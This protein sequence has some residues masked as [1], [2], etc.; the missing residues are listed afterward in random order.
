MVKGWVKIVPKLA[1]TKLRR[2]FQADGDKSQNYGTWVLCRRMSF[3][4]LKNGF[5]KSCKVWEISSIF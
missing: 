1:T 5:S 2:D 3:S 4:F